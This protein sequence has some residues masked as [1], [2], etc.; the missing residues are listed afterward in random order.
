MSAPEL[1]SIRCASAE[2]ATRVVRAMIGRDVRPGDIEV[3]SSEPVAEIEELLAGRSRLP[4]FVLLGAAAGIL[5]GFFLASGTAS[6]YP[7]NTGGMPII[8]PL[9]VGIV[10]YESM[11]LGAILCCFGTLLFEAKL[12][13]KR[14]RI[15]GEMAERIAD[16]DILVVDLSPPRREER[17]DK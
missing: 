11:M 3:I 6:L 4:G 8:S 12:L 2:E 13:R 17:R 7:I 14:P 10:T 9:P 16:G 15:E 5:A 1:K